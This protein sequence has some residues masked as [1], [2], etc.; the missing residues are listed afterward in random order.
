MKLKQQPEDFYVEEIIEYQTNSLGKYLLFWLKKKNL[1]TTDAIEKIS[2]KLK[3]PVKN[4]GYAGLKDKRAITLQLCS[5][6]E[7]N[8]EKLK[9]T[10]INNIEITIVGHSEKPV[11]I[12]QNKG[13]R[14][15][16]RVRDC[17]MPSKVN[18]EFVNYYGEQRFSR[19]NAEIGELMVK[20]EWK[21]AAEMLGLNDFRDLQK[22]GAR[23]LMIYI[24]AYQSKLW[25][26]AAAHS[27]SEEVPIPGFSNGHKEF[28]FKE[29]PLLSAEGGTRKRIVRAENVKIDKTEDGFM[30]SFELPKGSYATEFVKSLILK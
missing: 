27:N 2:K 23:K 13:N 14:F 3:I 6:K 17:E 20:R 7:A 25:N 1:N 8:E 5:V 9:E 26:E 19:N 18:P 29:I 28:I 24:N 15:V 21:K 16:I 22:I 30:I 10:K 12:G 11:Y 4:F